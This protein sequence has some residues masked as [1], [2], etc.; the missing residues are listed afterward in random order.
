MK[1]WKWAVVVGMSVCAASRL[2]VAEVSQAT[3]GVPE[4]VVSATA[5][6]EEQPVGPYHQPEW[7][8]ERRF[9]T[10]R[11]YLQEQPYEM[12][13]EQWDRI[14]YY[15]DGTVEQRFSEELELGVSLGLGV[16]GTG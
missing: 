6:R 16:A 8:T 3:N 11:V 9:P 7:T 13:V 1:V 15:K 10:T 14:R 4:I 12:G 2:T 5:L